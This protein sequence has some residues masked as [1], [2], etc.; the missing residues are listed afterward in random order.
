MVKTGIREL[1]IERGK[2]IKKQRIGQLNVLKI[3]QA[4]L[5][6]RVSTSMGDLTH[7]TDLIGVNISISNWYES[8][9]AAINI[10]SRYQDINLNEKVRI[11]LKVSVLFV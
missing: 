8:E 7:L 10:F 9:S 11:F 6:S 3:R 5:T 2:E 1:A 4:Y